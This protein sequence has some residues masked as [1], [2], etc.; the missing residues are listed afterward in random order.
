MFYMR[1]YYAGA[2]LYNIFHYPA[3]VIFLGIPFLYIYGPFWAMADTCAES[4][5]KKIAYKTRL[6]V[7]HLDRAFRAVAYA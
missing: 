1:F 6:A 7:Y 4:V 5:T 3:F 2:L